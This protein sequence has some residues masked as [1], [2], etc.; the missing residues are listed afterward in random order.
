MCEGGRKNLYLLYASEFTKLELWDFLLDRL[1]SYNVK[2]LILTAKD[3]EIHCYAYLKNP[4]P[5]KNLSILTYKGTSP[6]IKQVFSNKSIIDVAKADDSPLGISKK[7]CIEVEK[8]RTRKK[9]KISLDSE[10]A[11]TDIKIDNI[12]LSEFQT[13]LIASMD[14]QFATKFEDQ[15]KQFSNKLIESTLELIK[16]NLEDLK[17]PNIILSQN[18]RPNSPFITQSDQMDIEVQKSMIGGNIELDQQARIESLLNKMDI[19]KE[20]ITTPK[21]VT[22]LNKHFISMCCLSNNQILTFD[23][24]FQSLSCYYAE[25]I[26]KKVITQ[27]LCN[28]LLKSIHEKRSVTGIKNFTLSNKSLLSHS[29]NKSAQKSLQA[30]VNK[31]NNFTL[32]HNHSNKI[33]LSIDHLQ[34][35]SGQKSL[36]D[37]RLPRNPLDSTDVKNCLQQVYMTEDGQKLTYM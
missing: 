14:K 35:K 8:S 36:F 37:E 1:K 27:K 9:T 25:L 18:L 33:L 12:L 34:N 23:N 30:S 17:R 20:N 28:S 10:A 21:A 5:K 4:F 6:E 11:K 7:E 31:I 3:S 26:T 15:F 2:E 16:H 22:E 24:D 19:K 32:S 13:Q 29:Q